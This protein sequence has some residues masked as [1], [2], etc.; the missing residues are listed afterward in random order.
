MRRD[1]VVNVLFGGECLGGANP[2]DHHAA[3]KTGNQGEG[4]EEDG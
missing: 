2:G 3:G 1:G 4:G